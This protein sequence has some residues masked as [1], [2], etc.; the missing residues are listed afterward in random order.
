MDYKEISIVLSYCSSASI[1]LPILASILRFRDLT[2]GLR[3]LA[4]YALVSFITD[5][6]S[7]LVLEVF[8]SDNF[9][10]LHYFTFVEYGLLTLYYRSLSRN[11]NI[12][13]F[14]VLSVAFFLLL[15]IIFSII[16]KS[17]KAFDAYST[18]IECILMIFISLCYFYSI[19]KELRI[20]R[21][22]RDPSFWINSGVLLYFAGTLFLFLC[23]DILLNSNKET[24]VKYWGI[25]LIINIIFSVFL[26][27]GIWI[28]PRRSST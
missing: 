20:V 19:F 7:L 25:N 11:K 15:D 12:R 3:I 5:F 17:I 24:Y 2:K 4:F 23:A 27:I 1:I 18:G 21:L 22:E 28:T 10:I 6:S 14:L 26:A 9:I 13:I 8:K 16:F